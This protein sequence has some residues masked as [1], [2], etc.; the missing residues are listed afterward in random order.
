MQFGTWNV[1][2]L[3]DLKLFQLCCMMRKRS[4]AFICL[5]DTRIP[6]SGSRILENGFVLITSGADDDKRTYAGVGFLIS[7]CIKRSIFSFK[8]ISD[9]L[10]YLKL[11]VKGGKA[12]FFNVY[13]P[14]GG[15]DYAVREQ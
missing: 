10:C 9:R 7:P 5:Q 2:G 11:R 6:T 14:R 12:T 3:S 13:A 15:Y 8:P 4:L 1:E